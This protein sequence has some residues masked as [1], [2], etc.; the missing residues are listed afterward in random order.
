MANPTMTLIASHTTGSGGEASYSFSSI[1]NTYTDLK[2]VS[3]ARYDGSSPQDV[4]VYF[5]GVN[6]NLSYKLLYTSNGT[7]ATSY[8]ASDAHFAVVTGSS[9]TSNTFNNFEMYIPNYLSA[10]NKSFSVDMV[11]EN[12]AT[13]NFMYLQA[14]LW[15]SSAINKVTF[16]PVSGNFVQYSTFYLYG[17]NNS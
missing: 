13:A 2:V 1:P 4:N 11:T 14:G 12:N 17:I 6:S 16:A 7:S 10:N 3:S 5:N 9:W 15:S 8:Q